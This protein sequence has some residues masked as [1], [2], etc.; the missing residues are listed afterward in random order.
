M[1]VVIVTGAA[2]DIGRVYSKA[3]A[4]AGY[5]VVTADLKSADS[6]AAEIEASGGTALAVEVD[7]SDRK[8]TEAMAARVLE[9]FGRIDG[10]VNNAAYYTAIVKKEFT[11]LSDA[12]WDYC[13]AVNVRGSWLCARAVAQP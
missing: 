3:L 8:S 5:G 13:F 6:V 7:V 4:Q 12:E 2:G 1:D 11:E 9:R 10:L